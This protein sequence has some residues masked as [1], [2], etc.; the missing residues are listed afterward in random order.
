MQHGTV[1]IKKAA[2]LRA[3]SGPEGSRKLRFPD[4][5][6][7]AQDGGKVVILTHR[8][9]WPPRNTQGTQFCQRL[10][11]LQGNS[12][13]GRIMS[14]KNSND[15]IGN[16]T[17]DLPVCSATARRNCIN[18]T[19]NSRDI[20]NIQHFSMFIK[21]QMATFCIL[22]PIWIPKVSRWQQQN[23]KDRRNVKRKDRPCSLSLNFNRTKR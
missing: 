9:P 8:P 5:M 14:L 6:K 16:R 19:L 15:T 22:Y 13:T 7:T 4:F 17:R 21:K 10:C 1:Y 18:R 2:P 20:N 23:I 11:R 3:W 12:R